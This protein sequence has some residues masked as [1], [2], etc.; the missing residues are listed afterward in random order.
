MRI[1][2]FPSAFL[3]GLA[4][5]TTVNANGLEDKK[6]KDRVLEPCTIASGTGSFYDLTSLLIKPTEEGKKPAKN[7]KTDS[8]HAKGHDYKSNFT[9]NVCAPVV[10]EVKDV[11]GIPSDHWKNVSA[12]YDYDGRTYSLG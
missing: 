5:H 3:L 1:S 4:L 2:T 6:P 8:W 12:Y 7:A 11:F 10:E 9:L